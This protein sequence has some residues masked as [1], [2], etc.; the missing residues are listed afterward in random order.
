MP[1]FA[2]NAYTRDLVSGG[3]GTYAAFAGRIY[4]VLNNE[5]ERVI[6]LDHRAKC[7]VTI[8]EIPEIPAD[9][10]AYPAE[11]WQVCNGRRVT[12]MRGFVGSQTIDFIYRRVNV[13]DALH[14][15]T[16]VPEEGCVS[17]QALL[18]DNTT[19]AEALKA[20]LNTAGIA[21]DQMR[22]DTA[23]VNTLPVCPVA[24]IC[25]DLDEPLEN[26]HSQ[27]CEYLGIR[28][29]VLP[30]SGIITYLPADQRP[31]EVSVHK[32]SSTPAADGCYPLLE[33]FP[34]REIG[35]FETI[36]KVVTVT[37]PKLTADDVE[38]VA[39][40]AT[41]VVSGISGTS[42]N[43]SNVF[44]QRVQDAAIIAEREAKLLCR[45][46]QQ[47]VAETIADAGWLPGQTALFKCFNVWGTSDWV[48]GYIISTA[49]RGTRCELVV[50]TGPSQ[51]DGYQQGCL[52]FADFS[53]RIVAQYT[54]SGTRYEVVLDATGSEDPDGEII[55]YQWALNAAGQAALV[56]PVT[57]P[58]AMV[59]TVVLNSITDVEVTLTITD[60]N[61]PGNTASLTLPLDGTGS[62]VYVRVVQTANGDTWSILPDT[63]AWQRFQRVG[64]TCLTVPR[65]QGVY[66]SVWNDRSIYVTTDLLATPATLHSTLPGAGNLTTACLFVNEKDTS[67]WLCGADNDLYR[68]R[69][70]GLTW[71]LVRSFASAVL[72]CELG[73]TPN[74]GYLR[75]VS[76]NEVWQSHSNGIEWDVAATGAVGTTAQA[77]SSADWGEGS[78]HLTVFTGGA[79]PADAWRFDIGEGAVINGLTSNELKAVTPHLMVPGGFTVATPG[80]DII[81]LS[82]NGNYDA[83]APLAYGSVHQAVRDGSVPA[84]VWM[85]GNPTG[86]IVNGSWTAQIDDRE[87][88]KIGYGELI[89]Y[90]PL[91]GNC[92]DTVIIDSVIA[93]YHWGEPLL[94]DWIGIIDWSTC[95]DPRFANATNTTR[96]GDFYVSYTQDQ[97]GPEVQPANVYVPLTPG[98]YKVRFLPN[99]DGSW[100][101]G[102]SNTYMHIYLVDA[103]G[104]GHVEDIFMGNIT[105]PW[106]NCDGLTFPTEWVTIT[107]TEQCGWLRISWNYDASWP[108]VWGNTQ[109]RPFRIE[110][111]FNPDVT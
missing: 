37:G 99:E 35:D 55:S 111:C 98:T 43:I 108:G 104:S 91:F 60:D 34:E 41:Y 40:E 36:V 100:P 2:H 97:Q 95:P 86:K 62:V 15:L 81:V 102:G 88:S 29:L 82:D 56:N 4:T 25:I 45:A 74:T 27:L 12:I 87:S 8:R 75:A 17:A 57:I 26:L 106:T 11:V 22:I 96:P 32:F 59:T 10:K 94:D 1:I 64:Y 109:T 103:S 92:S 19:G 65:F 42:A 68:S 107:Y 63:E 39:P 110:F 51:L 5:V 20:I 105:G 93:A 44:V 47:Y 38:G 76:G 72:D 3:N 14:K 61:D 18:F 71:E 101:C 50:S 52:P 33:P 89:N 6:S 48:P 84:L 30:Q 53:F 70:G 24:P 9:G 85:A 23:I 13:L 79:T 83:G 31:M 49:L 7:S 46:E 58:D 66:A 16:K 28:P 77:L 54:V 78:R 80:G 73:N 90:P 67:D 69:D 21:D